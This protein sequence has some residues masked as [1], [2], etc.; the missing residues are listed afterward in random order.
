VIARNTITNNHVGIHL[1]RSDNNA[2]NGNTIED[3]FH[4]VWLDISNGNAINGNILS[5]NTDTGSILAYSSNNTLQGNVLTSNNLHGILL[6]NSNENKITSNEI[7]ENGY[8]IALRYSDN[9]SIYHNNFVD[10]QLQIRFSL[11]SLN[12]WDDGYPSGGNYWSDYTGIDAYSG[13]YQNDTGSDGIG[14][15]PY[16]IDADNLDNYPLMPQYVPIAGDLNLDGT[17]DI[18]DAILAALAFGS[19]PEDPNWNSQADLNYD[20]IVDI[21]DVIILANNFGKH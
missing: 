3:N 11:E 13:P 20:N 1:L 2:I 21:F 15:T 17:V 7:S 18:S 19:R 9:N 12:I 5:N 10:N 16:V 6:D 14:D 4:G 8:G